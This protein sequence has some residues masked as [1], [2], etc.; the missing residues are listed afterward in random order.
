MQNVPVGNELI[1]LSE[2]KQ[3]TPICTFNQYLH[4]QH[5]YLV[6]RLVLRRF[7]L[8]SISTIKVLKLSGDNE[9]S[10]RVYMCPQEA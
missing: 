8:E 5:V 7:R 3:Q 1:R 6:L 2:K 10:A 9:V 4:I